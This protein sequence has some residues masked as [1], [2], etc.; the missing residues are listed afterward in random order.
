[1]KYFRQLSNPSIRNIPN[2]VDALPESLNVH[3]LPVGRLAVFE[4]TVHL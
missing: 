2:N 3:L 1:M 4:N